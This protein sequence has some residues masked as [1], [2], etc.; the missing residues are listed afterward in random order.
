[1]SFRSD[2]D[3]TRL[4]PDNA[5]RP[6]TF[7]IIAC[8]AAVWL[9]LWAKPAVATP[10]S[11]SA[12]SWNVSGSANALSAT[13]QDTLST[14][15]GQH[16]DIRSTVDSPRP[17]YRIVLDSEDEDGVTFD[18]HWSAAN[19]VPG[20]Y[21]EGYWHDG[22]TH[23]GDS[24]VTFTP[25]IEV[26]GS[27]EVFLRW[28]SSEN[29]ANNVPVEIAHA[30]G[31]TTVTVDQQ[32]LGGRWVSLGI[33]AFTAN[34]PASLT[35]HTTGTDGYVVA[36]AVKF[37]RLVA[38]TALAT[39]PLDARRPPA[40][41]KQSRSTVRTTG[42]AGPGDDGWWSGGGRYSSYGNGLFFGYQSR[43]RPY[44]YGYG[45][46]A[47]QGGRDAG[48]RAS[49]TVDIGLSGPCGPLSPDCGQQ[50]D[51]DS[52]QPADS[53]TD[54]IVVES[55]PQFREPGDGI[56]SDET[57]MELTSAN[58]APVDPAL[59]EATAFTLFRSPL[60]A[61][62][63]APAAIPVPEPTA[64]AVFLVGLLWLLACRHTTR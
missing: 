21:A 15:F 31:S 8:A 11:V 49:D 33:F 56:L 23:K 47:W 22:N 26:G 55:G 42:I 19:D 36:D 1:M 2:A 64:V 46:S 5:M 57:L 63:L 25:R 16:I 40:V 32:I 13:E 18:G 37:Q 10:L 48:P 27:Y 43:I 59:A 30:G 39:K 52:D 35:I 29:H 61:R 6:A 20:Y 3:L 7:C 44:G 41:W 50:S 9:G 58:L 34:E 60:A 51:T 38:L 4:A 54:L 53:L 24:R 14:L 17:R 28:T 62:S 45:G 12:A